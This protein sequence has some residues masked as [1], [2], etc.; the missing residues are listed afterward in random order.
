MLEACKWSGY[1][2]Q[3]LETKCPTLCKPLSVPLLRIEI[4]NGAIALNH[5][6]DS[7]LCSYCL[8]RKL[9]E[10]KGDYKHK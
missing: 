2:L 8:S 10:F 6:Y 9:V 4:H 3:P 5:G 1:N 7:D